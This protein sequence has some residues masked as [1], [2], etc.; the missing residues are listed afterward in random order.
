V[1][2][3]A[4]TP[5]HLAATAR[6]FADRALPVYGA[7]SGVQGSVPDDRQELVALARELRL[8]R[9]VRD[10]RL[11][12]VVRDT[13]EL[14]A[15]LRA[16]ADDRDSAGAGGPG[17]GVRHADLRGAQGPGVLSGDL[18][19]TRAYLAALWRGRR[20]DALAR[21]WLAGVDVTAADAAGAAPVLPLPTSVLLRGPLREDG[22]P[23]TDEPTP[24]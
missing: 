17:E 18:P 4:P 13:M 14:A 16:F 11:A 6:L 21:L 8:G 20:L 9:A 12:V 10:C 7:H 5:E 24:S 22:R 3:S 19:E 1:L 15:A 2:L 23:S